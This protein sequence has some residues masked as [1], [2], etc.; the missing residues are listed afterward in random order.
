MMHNTWKHKEII[1]I[2]KLIIDDEIMIQIPKSDDPE[3][4]H[5]SLCSLVFNQNQLKKYESNL[6]FVKRRDF[7]TFKEF[8]NKFT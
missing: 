4:V 5:T 8:Y 1:A 6:K 7:N 2:L 3:T